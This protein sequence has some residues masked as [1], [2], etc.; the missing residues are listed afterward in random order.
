[1]AR[2]LK[3]L[4]QQLLF[5]GCKGQQLWDGFV[6]S[7]KGRSGREEKEMEAEGLICDLFLY[8]DFFSPT[9]ESNQ[10]SFILHWSDQQ[11]LR[12]DMQ[13]QVNIYEKVC[14]SV[15]FLFLYFFSHFFSQQIIMG[16]ML[17][18]SCSVVTKIRHRC[19]H[20]KGPRAYRSITGTHAG[21][22]VIGSR[23]GRGV[24]SAKYM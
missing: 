10:E 5:P 4:A 3:W 19:D 24:G 7:W 11:D 6:N 9:K 21:L 8:Y 22:S 1:M 14:G 20:P 2:L 17:N 16:F 23:E 15:A 12:N 18:A 13:L